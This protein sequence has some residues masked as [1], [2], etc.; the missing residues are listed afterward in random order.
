MS[1]YQ[2]AQGI[3]DFLHNGSQVLHLTPWVVGGWKC[4][5][6][7]SLLLKISTESTP[8]LW[9]SW[10]AWGLGH[11]T[12]LPTVWMCWQRHLLLTAHPTQRT[13]PWLSYFQW[14]DAESTSFQTWIT[15]L[16][17]SLGQAHLEIHI[18]IITTFSEFTVTMSTKQL[19]KLGLWEI[20][21]W[22]WLWQHGK[23]FLL[24]KQLI[25]DSR[26]PFYI[27]PFSLLFTGKSRAEHWPFRF[28][29]RERLCHGR[30]NRSKI[31]LIPPFSPVFVCSLVPI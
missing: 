1:S 7:C 27:N 10:G 2:W 31:I 28:G 23:C 11:P 21:K 25:C 16:G 3:I 13:G 9:E 24:S 12:F 26:Q 14:P 18:N 29:V 30:N 8:S 19:G 4:I 6:R 20:G 17:K 22:G 15:R 5:P